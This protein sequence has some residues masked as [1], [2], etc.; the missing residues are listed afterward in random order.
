VSVR[1][2]VLELV[3]LALFPRPVGVPGLSM[4]TAAR[5]WLHCCH[6]IET[7]VMKSRASDNSTDTD[8]QAPPR[9]AEEWRAAA[10][11]QVL[12][13]TRAEEEAASCKQPYVQCC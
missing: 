8:E 2:G 1:A 5:P 4:A 10:E 7:N 13:E 9:M 3:Y 6:K 12:A 11:R